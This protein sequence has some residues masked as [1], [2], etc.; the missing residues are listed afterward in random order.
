MLK[1]DLMYK[2]HSGWAVGRVMK[3]YTK[4]TQY[5]YWVQYQ[6]DD[7]ASSMYPEGLKAPMY[8]NG[9]NCS[10]IWFLIEKV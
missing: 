1:R 3:G 4:G 10:G 2:W 7:G 8:Y 9:S 5:N 6:E